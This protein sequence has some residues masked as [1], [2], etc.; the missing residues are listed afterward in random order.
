[1]GL[2]LN[3]I[4]GDFDFQKAKSLLENTL[5]LQNGLND[6]L[7]VNH[8]IRGEAKLNSS[9]TVFQIPLIDT[10]SAAKFNT[11]NLLALQ[12][13][14]VINKI[15]VFIGNP[16]SDTDAQYKLYTYGDANVFTD[17]NVAASIE[18]LYNNANLKYTNNQRVVLPYWDLKRHHNVPKTQT[19]A[20]AFFSESGESLVNS[21]D[22][23][24]DG[25]YPVQ[26]SLLLNGGGNAILEL[27]LKQALTAT[28]TYMRIV[29]ILR[30]IL[31]QNASAIK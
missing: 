11:M 4:T 2:Q 20:N 19:A 17:A 21:E 27:D 28:T 1:M 10:N 16:S 9:S 7:L 5:G 31:L 22:G 3:S 13:M 29:V 25:F 12:D 15:G 26:P 8:T 23:T 24:I 18:G 14:F 30:G 6:N